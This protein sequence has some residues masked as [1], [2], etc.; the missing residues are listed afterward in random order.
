MPF[1][2]RERSVQTPLGVR[3]HPHGAPIADSLISAISASGT[4]S[5]IS[6]LLWKYHV[7]LCLS[8]VFCYGRDQAM[9]WAGSLQ[10][11]GVC[12]VC[13]PT[14]CQPWLT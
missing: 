10:A 3:K 2:P 1:P 8:A 9:G 5:H 13:R 7:A 4:S 11:Q 14:L 12:T 6:L